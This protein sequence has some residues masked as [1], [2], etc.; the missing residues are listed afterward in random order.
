M[1][2]MNQLGTS[3]VTG[4]SNITIPKHVRELMKLSNGDLVVFVLKNGEIVVKR[5][6]VK[7]DD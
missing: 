6:T 2:S 1:P 7:V 5:G 3:R 4:K